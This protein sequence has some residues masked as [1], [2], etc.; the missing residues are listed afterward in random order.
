EE[1]G[2]AMIR[3]QLREG[4]TLALDLCSGQLHASLGAVEDGAAPPPRPYP[5]ADARW[6]DNLR[7]QLRPG[8]LDL[9]GPWRTEGQRLHADI[10]IEDG[11][12]VEASW[13]C[14]SEAD[15]IAAELL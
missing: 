1:Q 10:E 11:S 9:S 7:T 8:G 4:F 14:R 6:L 5:A 2:A 3:G 15:L 13:V 12:R